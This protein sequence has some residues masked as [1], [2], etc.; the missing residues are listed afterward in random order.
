[1]VVGKW[2]YIIIAFMQLYNTTYT[3]AGQMGM[4]VNTDQVTV[5]VNI[6]PQVDAGSDQTVCVEQ[7]SRYLEVEPA[8]IVGT[9]EL[10]II[11]HSHFKYH[12][13]LHSNNR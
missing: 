9:M 2:S 12:H 13:S 6:L 7:M 4:V 5:T 11:R 3:V 1:M 10:P 8:H